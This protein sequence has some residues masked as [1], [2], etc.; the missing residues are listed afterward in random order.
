MKIQLLLV[1]LTILLVAVAPAQMYVRAG[2]GYG[3]SLGTMMVGTDRSQDPGHPDNTT[4][5]FG[6]FG[7]GASFN[8]SIG[9]EVGP[10]ALFDIGVTYQA[11]T[12]YDAANSFF[13]MT[14]S[15]KGH[16]LAI[17]PAL[18][19][20]T[21]LMG[22]QPFVRLGM[23]AGFPSL[24]MD[25]T[26]LYGSY[27]SSTSEFSGPPAWGLTGALGVMYPV[28]PNLRV[29]GELG[30]TSISW[31]P[32]KVNYS[33]TSNGVTT[34]Q[35]FNLTDKYTSLDQNTRG[36]QGMPFGAYGVNIGLVYS[37]K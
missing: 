27:A 25:S 22:V 18:T 23:V 32:D 29:L 16:M 33:V 1:V 34:S 24:K 10:N 36:S 4:Y 2:G 7:K 12:A 30:F 20:F 8:G 28:T 14:S 31:T 9:T 3:L 35:E 26:L 17:V 19:I 15:S 6:S 11:G 37:F 5:N 13:G 21:D